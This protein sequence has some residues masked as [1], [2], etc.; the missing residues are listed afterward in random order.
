MPCERCRFSRKKHKCGMEH[1]YCSKCGRHEM[2]IFCEEN[3][4]L[5][6]KAQWDQAWKETGVALGLLNPDGSETLELKK[7]RESQKT[8]V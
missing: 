5:W 6:T 2:P 3:R 7:I 8:K 1:L 4:C